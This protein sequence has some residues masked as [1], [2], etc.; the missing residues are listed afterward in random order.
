MKFDRKIYFDHVRR[1]PFDGELSQNQVDGQNFLLA[2]WEKHPLSADLRHIAYALATTFHETA[3]TMLP[4]AEYGK[5]KGKPYGNVDPET[6]Q[7]YFGRGYC[8]LTWRD[9][10]SKA[11][12][13]LDLTGADDLVLHADRAMDPTIAARIIYL[14]MD[15][16]WFRGDS[17][18][19]QTQSRY[20]DIDTD[21][22]FNAREIINGDRN[23]VPNWSGGKSIGKLIAGY[24]EDFLAA[25]VASQVDDVPEP[26]PE[27]LIVTVTVT[28]PPG[29]KV[30]VK[31]EQPDGA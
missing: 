7:V 15:E 1:R 12:K 3:K 5:G 2:V 31:T 14:G 13:V 10:Y 23:V 25:L 24:H 22:P 20:F 11:T 21:D 27:K 26:E 17:Q 6:G 18:G 30:I 4:I 29:V 8:Q 16:G 19:R 28:A 9:N